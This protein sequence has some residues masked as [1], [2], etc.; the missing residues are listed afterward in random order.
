VSWRLS[1][2]IE[3]FTQQQDPNRDRKCKW[4]YNGQEKGQSKDKGGNKPVP[5]KEFAGLAEQ[6]RGCNRNRSAV[7]CPP[8]SD[9]FLGHALKLGGPGESECEEFAVIAICGYDHQILT[10]HM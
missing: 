7:I 6:R 4:N 10:M 9:E 5:Q 8:G 2:K 3:D 1:G